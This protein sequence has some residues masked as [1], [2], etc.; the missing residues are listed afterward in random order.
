MKF[1]Y[2]ILITFFIL[3]NSISCFAQDVNLSQFYEL[4]LL[5]NPALAGIFGGDIRIVGAYRN[6]WQSISSSPYQTKALGG[7][8]KFSLGEFSNDYLTLGFQISHDVAGD[9]K[10]GKLQLMPAI[11]FH[12]SINGEKDNYLSA[13]LIAGVVQQRFDPSRLQFDD[14]FV[15]GSYS[16]ANPTRQT[17]NRTNLLYMDM[18]AGI[19]YNSV[20][21][22]DIHY[23]VGL[24]AYHFTKPTVAFLATNDVKLNPKLVVNFGLT[25]P[26]GEE[27]KL[28]VYG[29]FFSQGQS[30]QIQGGLLYSHDLIKYSEDEKIGI[31][32]GLFYKLNDA[33][34]PIVKLEY[35]SL[36][37][38]LS[39]DVNINKLAVATSFRG[40]TELT[41]NYKTY[42][43]GM[44]STLLRSR[45]PKF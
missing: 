31:S 45:C 1:Y 37:V 18:G 35:Y 11:N 12:K 9:S 3:T 27:D 29:D 7:E 36:S 10:L 23:Y 14:Q 28:T 26:Y 20:A 17:F 5:R 2:S 19:A 33:L 30:K 44:N 24:S 43:K 21:G 34:I 41:L 25:M 38:G 32:A 40:G 16:A 42:L 39:Y 8:F 6:Q 22:D 4:P 13:G 15:N